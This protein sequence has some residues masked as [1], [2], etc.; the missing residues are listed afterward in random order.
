MTARLI[1]T[2]FLKTV[3]S[4]THPVGSGP[5]LVGN[6]GFD[7]MSIRD[8]GATIFHHACKYGIERRKSHNPDLFGRAERSTHAP[9][10]SWPLV[11]TNPTRTECT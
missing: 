6:N 10:Q 9:P 7:S 2:P 3:P 5:G 4:V 1:N 8:D 11:L